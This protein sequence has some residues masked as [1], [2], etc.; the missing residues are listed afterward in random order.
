[1]PLSIVI[2][3]PVAAALV[4]ALLP[5]RLSGWVATLGAAA[6]LGLAVALVVGFDTGRQGLQHVTD[7]L[8]IAALGIHYKLGVDGLN[9]WLVLLTTVVFLAAMLGAALREWERPRLFFFHLGLAE[10]AVLGA[11]LAQDLLLFVGFFDLMLIPFYFLVGQWGGAN[12]VAA[13]TKLVIYTLVGSLLMLAGAIATGVLAAGQGDGGQLSFALSDLAA[14]PLGGGT[15]VW[16]FL[17]FAAAFFVKMP[18][19][20]LHGWVPDAYRAMPLPVLAAFGAVLSKVAAYGFLRVVLPLY[21]EASVDLQTLMLLFAL[22]SILYGSVMAFT[23]TNVRLIL[24]YSSI[25]Q[26]GFI[27]LGIFSLRTAGAEG[28]IFQMVNH[29]LVVAPLFFVVA[30]LRARAHG[31]E[32]IRDMGGVGFR[33]PVF[34][35]MFLIVTFAT[36]AMPGSANFIGEYLILLGTFQSKVVY[37]FVAATGVVLAAVYA[38]R[39]FI[40]AVHNRVGPDVRSREMSLRDALVIVPL[41]AAIVALGVYPQVALERIRAVAGPIMRDTQAAAARAPAGDRAAAPEEAVR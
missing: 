21:P 20:P 9:L 4:G 33:A 38:L 22:A 16:I 31:S 29:G 40:R 14:R 12:R 30:V 5:R 39:M 13:T 37:A 41:V 24:A 10:T 3:L 25:A 18:V 6:T 1:M 2:W 32:D 23:Q 11:F 19:F 15:Q 8:W 34:A 35:T 17:T 27:L 28:A 26:L 7:V 36:L